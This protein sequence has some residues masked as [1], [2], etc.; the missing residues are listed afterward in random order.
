MTPSQLDA[1]QRR[2]TRDFGAEVDAILA[3]FRCCPVCGGDHSVW[4]CPAPELDAGRIFAAM[5]EEM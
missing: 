5:M 4:S 1:G 2:F 3:R